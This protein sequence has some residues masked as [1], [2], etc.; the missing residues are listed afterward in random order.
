MIQGQAA[1]VTEPVQTM[2]Q[3]PPGP[4]IS[5]GLTGGQSGVNVQNATSQ[6]T[7]PPTFQEAQQPQANSMPANNPLSDLLAHSQRE[8][9]A[10]LQRAREHFKKRVREAFTMSSR[11]SSDLTS[12]SLPTSDAATFT[13]NSSLDAERDRQ[14]KRLKKLQNGGMTHRAL[15]EHNERMARNQN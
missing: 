4:T 12:S 3:A 6:F 2:S 13:Y 14:K 5:F 10:A 8:H 1:N 9:D 7:L 15:Q 11:S